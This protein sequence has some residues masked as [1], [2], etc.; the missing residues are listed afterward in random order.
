MT[1]QLRD[2]CEKYQRHF[3]ELLKVPCSIID[4]PA[5]EP[6]CYLRDENGD[7][8]CTKCKYH[9]DPDL[10]DELTTR[11]YGCNEAHRWN[12]KYIYYC[13]MGLVFIAA[14]LI[15]E[16][17]SLT[18]GIVIGPLVMGDHQDV[19]FDLPDQEMAE[20]IKNIKT[21]STQEVY[22]ISEIL[23]CVCSEIS[24]VEEQKY[25]NLMFDQEKILKEI[26]IAK[27]YYEDTSAQNADSLLEFEKGLRAAFLRGEKNTALEMLNEMLAHIYVYSNYDINSVKARM[28]E[29]LVVLSRATIEAGA[30]TSEVFRLSEGYIRQIERGNDIDQLAVW[31]SDIVRR[32]IIQAFDLA[33]VKHSDVVF[34]VTNYIKRNCNEKL[35][36]DALAREVYLSKSYLSSMFKEETGI[37][38][39]EYITKVRIEKSKRLLTENSI[40]ISAIAMQCGFKDQSYFTKVFKKETGTS[41]KKYRNNY[42]GIA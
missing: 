10:K 17:S 6:P 37:S 34:K 35:S 33:Q 36:L 24:G 32:F 39:T 11:L 29:L 8:F 21:Y 19:L 38:L 23:T 9:K 7:D 22:H 12:G 14:S 40:S 13:P 20:D 5:N 31:M 18:G 4:L 3:S 42:F 2:K 15:D 26:Y 27:D 28:L 30:D 41:P 16:F 1:P 25:R